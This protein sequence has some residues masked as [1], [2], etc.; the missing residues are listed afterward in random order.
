MNCKSVHSLKSRWTSDLIRTH[1]LSYNSSANL[2][3]DVQDQPAVDEQG[4]GFQTDKLT[5]GI[6]LTMNLARTNATLA[7][8]E[9]ESYR[10]FAVASTLN[11]WDWS[12]GH[13]SKMPCSKL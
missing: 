11:R 12:T 5:Y 2:G 13:A 10:F 6:E 4:K 1:I 3:C 8:R 9:A 7:V